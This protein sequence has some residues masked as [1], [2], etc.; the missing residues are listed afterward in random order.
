MTLRVLDF[1]SNRPSSPDEI[2]HAKFVLKALGDQRQAQSNTTA[3]LSSGYD[4]PLVGLGTWKSEPG[5]VSA[6]VKAALGSGYRHIDCAS[7]YKN[8]DEVGTALA[9]C[10]EKGAVRREDIFITSKLWYPSVVFL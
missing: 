1:S 5:Q 3:S 2:L 6:A 10:I 4:I 9:A 8:E 7:I